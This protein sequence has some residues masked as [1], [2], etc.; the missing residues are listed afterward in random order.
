MGE[1]NQLMEALKKASAEPEARQAFYGLLLKTDI[2]VPGRGQTDENGAPVQVGFKQWSQPDGSLAIPFF[3]DAEDLKKVLGPEEPYLTFPA[4]GLFQMT[5]GSTLVL[6][7]PGG[8]SKSFSPDEVD[9]LLSSALALDPLA[10]ALEQAVREGSEEAK[11]H[12]YQVF[13]NSRLFVF[14]EPRPKDGM[15]A[16]QTL[17]TIGPEDR[18]NIATIAHPQKEGERIIPFF[19]SSELLH[20]AARGANL[21]PQTTFLGFSA[22]V[23]LQMARHM[24][25][26]LVLNL[27]PSTYKKIFNLDEISYILDN[28]RTKLYEDRLLPAGSQIQ[29]APPKVYPQELVGAMLEFLPAFRAVNAAYLTTMK[30]DIKEDLT[31][32]EAEPGLVIGLETEVEVDLSE[33]LN[34]L[35]P[36]VARH[37][38]PGQAVDFTLV[39]PGEKGLS[40]L[41]RTKVSPFYRRSLSGE[42]EPS[43]PAE[44]EASA[45]TEEAGAPGLFGRLKRIFKG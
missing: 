25:L 21:P 41:L 43:A 42:A 1:A 8:L 26:P 33:M 22:L 28:S 39:K 37:A 30:E 16:P 40:H 7:G 20:R 14:G 23:L 45:R 18:F 35:A 44:P 5:R 9:M 29:L 11:N 4:L 19:S 36:L 32:T 3:S 12:F 13:V 6:I 31:F 34:R 24:G 10:E 38:P 15:P 17:T 2:L 27:G